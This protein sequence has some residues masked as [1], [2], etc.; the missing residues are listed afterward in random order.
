M[1]D[2][3]LEAL[4]PWVRART[5]P[6]RARVDL[7][8]D[9]ADLFKAV[10][11]L[12]Q[13]PWGYLSAV[14]GLDRGARDGGLEVLYHFCEGPDVLTLRVAVPYDDPHVPSLCDLIPSARLYEQELRE[15]FGVAV[16]GLADH[17]NLF[18]P[19]DWREGD[20]PLRKDAV[21]G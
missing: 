16:D 9:V 10:A 8:V 20:Y 12:R 4:S 5:E 3:P 18:L 15:L 1:F 19:D 6:E 17:G 11:A 13:L 7:V 2:K 21:L 14:T